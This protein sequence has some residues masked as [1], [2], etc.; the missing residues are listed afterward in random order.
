MYPSSSNKKR[1]VVQI[2]AYKIK[3]KT[4]IVRRDIFIM[5]S[6]LT[7]Q[8]Y[9]TVCA[10][11]NRT[12]KYMIKI[13]NIDRREKNYPKI[14]FWDSKHPPQQWLKQLGKM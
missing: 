7:H 14:M 6:R 11:N 5:I 10:H 13:D 4:K 9:I 1:A 12:W 3:F 2:L 8:E